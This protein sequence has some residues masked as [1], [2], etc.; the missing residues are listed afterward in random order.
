MSAFVVEMD[1]G[2]ESNIR[3]AKFYVYA[4]SLEDAKNKVFEWARDCNFNPTG[5]KVRLARKDEALSVAFWS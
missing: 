5:S 1:I 4:D 2:S 3:S